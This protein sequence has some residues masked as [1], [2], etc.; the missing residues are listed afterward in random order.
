MYVQI[1]CLAHLPVLPPL[2]LSFPSCPRRGTGLA[3]A[4]LPVLP[5]RGA[6]FALAH[7]PVPPQLPY[8][9]I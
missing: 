4:H 9:V 3:L 7:L 8:R 1:E 5:M 6:G 2:S